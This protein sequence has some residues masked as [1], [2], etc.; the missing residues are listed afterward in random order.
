MAT[1][2]SQEPSYTKAYINGVAFGEKSTPDYTWDGVFV[3]NKKLETKYLPDVV[4]NQLKELSGEVSSL[5]DGINSARSTA[6]SAL[7]NANSALNEVRSVRTA[8]SEV[9]TTAN[10]AQTTAENAQTTADKAQTTAN[11]AQTTA[12]NAQST[13]NKAQTTA[14]S[15]LSMLPTVTSTDSGKFLRVSSAGKWVAEAIASAEGASF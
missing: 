10:N 4:M 2:M 6:D 1:R 14:Q 7:T 11:N 13:A 5:W 15:A 8:V 9:K 12:S 3:E